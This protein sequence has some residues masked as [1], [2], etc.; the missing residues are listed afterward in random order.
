M[1]GGGFK[2]LP[3]YAVIPAIN[4]ILTMAKEGKHG[5]RA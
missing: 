5:A 3:T 1:H 2:A 4:G